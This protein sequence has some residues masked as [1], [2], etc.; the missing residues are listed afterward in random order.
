M[1]ALTGNELA[2]CQASVQIHMAWWE[3]QSRNDYAKHRLSDLDIL[4]K[5]L[6]AILDAAFPAD[7]LGEIDDSK[8]DNVL[9]DLSP[10]FPIADAIEAQ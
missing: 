8:S 9:F 6:G 7:E 10:S 4:N 1:E 3:K 2:L 5:K